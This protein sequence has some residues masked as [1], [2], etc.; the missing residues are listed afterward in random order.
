[1]R[2]DQ[3]GQIELQDVPLQPVGFALKPTTCGT[4]TPVITI[5]SVKFFPSPRGSRVST[6]ATT[7]PLTIGGS[8][9]LLVASPQRTL[10]RRNARWGLEAT[11]DG[12]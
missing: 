6:I 1:M 7:A 11:G 12:G 8:R 5:D 3:R 4:K 9:S 2:S 10:P